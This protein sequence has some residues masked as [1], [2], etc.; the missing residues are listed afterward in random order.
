MLFDLFVN[1]ELKFIQYD[2][3]NPIEYALAK[4][5][6][7]FFS[8]LGT[9]ISIL[10]VFLL[11]SKAPFTGILIMSNLPSVVGKSISNCNVY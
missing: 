4:L 10:I 8:I 6:I 9:F 2:L 11:L 5:P 3:N 1:Y 7:Y